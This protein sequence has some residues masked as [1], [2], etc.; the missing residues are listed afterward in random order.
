MKD[1]KL[2]LNLT[3]DQINLV[4]VALAKLPF[5][6]SAAIIN[7]I[8]TQAE[9]QMRKDISESPVVMDSNT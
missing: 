4:L 1:L 7:E 6:T 8:K 5:E 9:D 3:V 2:S